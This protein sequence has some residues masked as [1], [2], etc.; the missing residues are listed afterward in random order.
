M[1][2]VSYAAARD[3]LAAFHYTSLR[4]RV[5]GVALMLVG[6]VGVSTGLLAVGGSLATIVGTGMGVYGFYLCR[7]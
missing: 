4:H 3:P 7:R 6:G 1:P 5:Q 2:P